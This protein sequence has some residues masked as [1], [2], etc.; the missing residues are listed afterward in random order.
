MAITFPALGGQAVTPKQSGT[1]TDPF[2]QQ[3]AQKYGPPPVKKIAPIQPGS[4]TEAPFKWS[5]S[6][7]GKM[8]V[9]GA[10]TAGI[11]ASKTFLTTPQGT[12]GFKD[13]GM[14]S[15]KDTAKVVPNALMDALNLV[16]QGTYGTIKNIAS[17]P[18]EA[19][20]LIKE[21]GGVLPAYKNYAKEF[22]PEAGKTAWGMVPQSA[23]EIANTNAIEDIPQQFHTLAK[24]SGGYV[25]ALK[26]IAESAP[27]SITP[28][29]RD[30]I[31]QID[32]ARQ[33]VINH[34]LNEALGY[35]GLKSLTENPVGTAK[36]ASEGIKDT[37]EFATKPIESMKSVYDTTVKEP[38][39]KKMEGVA[40]DLSKGNLDPSIMGSVERMNTRAK[41]PSF[42][43]EPV[44]K[45]ALQA[46]DEFYAHANKSVSDTKLPNAVDKY[47]VPRTVDAI[48]TKIIPTRKE[49]GAIMGEEMKRLGGTKIDISPSIQ[50]FE[51]DLLDRAGIVFDKE[52]RTVTGGRAINAPGVRESALDASDR[53]FV[54]DYANQLN[55]LGTNPTVQDVANFEKRNRAV[56]QKALETSKID[57]N[58]AS[59]VKNHA[60]SL[61]DELKPS[62]NPEFAK[63]AE[64]R[65]KYREL[66]QFL[67]EGDARLGDDSVL[68][69]PTKLTSTLKSA[70]RSIHSAGQKDW[71]NKLEELTGYDAIDDATLA[72]QAMRDAGDV[73]GE[74]LLGKVVHGSDYVPM[75]K[76]GFAQKG[77]EYGY[78]KL[79]EKALGSASEQTRRS[80]K[81]MFEEGGNEAIATGLYSWTTGGKMPNGVIEQ[82]KSSPIGVEELPFDK[83]GYITLYRDGDVRA[84]EPQSYSLKKLRGQK[85]YKIKKDNVLVNFNSLKVDD[86]YQKSFSPENYEMIK[87][88]RKLNTHESEVIAIQ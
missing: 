7:G 71:L 15:I 11:P 88:Q 85:P 81:S 22:T 82:L 50:K 6:A 18:G 84:G 74:S 77:L 64:A 16:K 20:G 80:L 44:H 79:K 68:G 62:T 78:G 14:R 5:V 26:H 36:A 34:P 86:I 75:T 61:M 33:S 8:D 31:N 38:I 35:M 63:Y 4:T 87:D 69:N 41:K 19:A 40:V 83:N 52:G 30:Y 39:A 76:T 49:A 73:K 2:Q 67:E 28:A 17:I 3:L 42:G 60:S 65:A 55:N 32:R 12:E 48:E 58:V 25:N 57:K 13:K 24:E 46:Y 37:V 54:Q 56:V 53:A 66:S 9:P 27:E 70:V 1:S 10:E 21:S 47:V 29:V 45:S 23:K 72:F 51:K 43:D 59:I